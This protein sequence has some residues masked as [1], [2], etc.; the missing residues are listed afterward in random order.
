MATEIEGAIELRKAIRKYAPN[1]G[2]E[3]TKEIGRVLR[4]LVTKAKGFVPNEAPLSGWANP[5][6]EWTYRVYNASD[7]RRGITF[8][9]APSK[10]NRKGF[11]ALVRIIN[12]SA[13]GEIYEVAGRKNPHGQ[14]WEA[15]S[16]S[17]QLSHSA[18]RNAGRQFI[19]AIDAT[20]QM[21]QANQSTG[22]GRRGRY[23]K[24]RLIF[25]AWAEDQGKANAA[26]LKA[27]DS[28]N[29]DF[30]FMAGEGVKAA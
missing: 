25:R 10:P 13:A 23:A 16:S 6:G 27:I 24:G 17:K 7:I 3:T 2:K 5:V 1:L 19:D 21:S 22:P 14:P 8:S 29:K 4:P 30:A 15:N 18:N 9:S 28:A 11:R 26:V 12:K 20:G